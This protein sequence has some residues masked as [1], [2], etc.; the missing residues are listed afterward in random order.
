MLLHNR[1]DGNVIFNFWVTVI[2]FEFTTILIPYIRNL[3]CYVV[4]I[5]FSMVWRA[6][7]YGLVHGILNFH[8]K[9]FVG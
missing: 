1:V 8:I 5:L 2:S 9:N 4:Q 7:Y 3:M 6:I